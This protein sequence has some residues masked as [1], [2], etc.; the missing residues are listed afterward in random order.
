MKNDMKVLFIIL[1]ILIIMVVL[2]IIDIENKT[3]LD[4]RETEL[5]YSQMLEMQRMEVRLQKLEEVGTWQDRRN[6]G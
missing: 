6:R 3:I 1:T 5:Q 4:E 2:L